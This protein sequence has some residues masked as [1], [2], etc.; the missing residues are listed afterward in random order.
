MAYTLKELNV[1]ARHKGL[2]LV[3]GR[4]YFYWAIP[5][6]SYPDIESV[7]VPHFNRL[8]KDD[9]IWELKEASKQYERGYRNY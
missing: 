8:D 4:G 2:E 5:I 1:L 3:K 6:Q 7:S 9:W